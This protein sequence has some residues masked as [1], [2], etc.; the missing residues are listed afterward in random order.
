MVVLEL[1]WTIGGLF[2]QWVQGLLERC[3]NLK[4]LTIVIEENNRYK[5]LSLVKFQASMFPLAREFAQV[6]VEFKF[7]YQYQ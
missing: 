3:P 7:D 4:K 6:D 5:F 2:K 1:G